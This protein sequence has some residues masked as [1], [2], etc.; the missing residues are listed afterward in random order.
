MAHQLQEI[1]TTIK[2]QLVFYDFAYWLPDITKSLGIKSVCYH[3]VSATSLAFALVP[4]RH[5][6]D[7]RPIYEEE[8]R[9]PPPGFPSSSIL[10]RCH[11]ILS[12]SILS[13]PFGN[14]A[15][16]FY[17]RL[18]R[19]MQNCDALAVRSCREL[20]GKFCDYIGTQ[21]GK[22]LLFT[23]LALPEPTN[24]PA[25]EDRWAK[26]LEKFE[27]GSVVFCA[28]GSQY[29]IEKD[30]FQELVLGFELTGLPFFVALKPPIG[31]KTIEEAL[32][33]GF[34]ERVKERG[35][36]H[37]GWIQQTLIL[38][39]PSIGC[40]VSH[41]GFGSMMEGLMSDN[42]IVLV[43]DLV[44]QILN[45]KLLVE[46]LKV[47]VEVNRELENRWFSKESLSKAIDSVM[48]KESEVGMMVKANHAKV[49][50]VIEKPGLMDGYI[51]KFVEDLRQLV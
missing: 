36:V 26:W 20:E 14:G 27:I 16:K 38:S 13:R 18:T 10:L 32:P 25:L 8:A 41:C 22:S 44:D 23:G 21:Y 5:V 28:F 19:G 15:I 42:Q 51:D 33:H 39:H 50:E 2:P 4:A 46:E 17:E 34:E 49:K 3:V 48:D 24:T 12:M 43:P 11:E 47:A 7:H 31:C 1:L 29:F 9:E 45:T 37:G 35:V 40:F 6:P 30:Q